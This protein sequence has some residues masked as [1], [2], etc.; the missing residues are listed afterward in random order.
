MRF[1][2]VSLD[3]FLVETSTQEEMLALLD[4]MQSE[5]PVGIE[6]IVPAARTLLIRYR[7][8]IVDAQT[9]VNTISRYTFNYLVHAAG[10]VIDIPVCYNGEDLSEVAHILGIS[11]AEVIRQHTQTEF[12]VAFTGFAPGFAYLSGNRNLVVPRKTSP[13][14]WI[15]AGA[16]GLA[17]EFSGIYPKSSP[18]GWQLI[19]KTEKAMWDPNRTVPALLQPGMRVHFYED[20]HRTLSLP[21]VT[22]DVTPDDATE[23]ISALKVIA[24][25]V[26]ML[27][28][29]DGRAGQSS[30]GVSCAGAL[31]R[32]A[33]HSAN[34]AVGNPSHLPCLEFIPGGVVLESQTDNLVAV[35]GASCTLTLITQ[36]GAEHH[37]PGW[38]PFPLVKGDRLLIGRA[39][40]GARSYLAIRGGFAV[41]P[42]AGSA[43]TDT[44]A[45]LGPS[46][47][48]RGTVLKRLNGKGLS[49]VASDEKPNLPLPIIGETT[50]LDVIMG[51]R[52]DWFTSDAVNNFAAQRWHVT[53]HS[54]RIGLR[55]AG[56]TALTRLIDGELPSEGAR[57]GAIQIP[58]NGQ[59]VVFLADYPLT[60]GY[61]VIAYVAPWHLDLASQLPPGAWIHFRPVQAFRTLTSNLPPFLSRNA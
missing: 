58:A 34:R 35:T 33:Y 4:K 53:P 3:A 51:P 27:Y 47:V 16:V 11:T 5:T 55:L 38:Q 37:L 23:G 24:P 10:R 61:P 18:G 42:V 8:Y 57:P 48:T 1:L 28:Q 52:T 30:Q 46:P 44:L 40:Q 43:S 6:E 13:R 56:E 31:D 21:P 19:G 9:L 49:A 26:E 39:S 17:G 12:T 29:D 15:P 50:V 60:G 22:G 59:P 36:T 7:P 32:G 20:R 2:P 45:Q 14:L 54:S 41:T 25:G